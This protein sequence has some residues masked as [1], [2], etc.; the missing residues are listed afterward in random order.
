MTLLSRLAARTGEPPLVIRAS[1]MLRWLPAILGFSTA[2][3]LYV[4]VQSNR[5]WVGDD[6]A[7]YLRAGERF[8]AG[9]PIYEGQVTNQL[10]FLYGPPWAVAV[11]LI[12]L[13]PGAI[14]QWLIL[15][16]DLACLRYLAGSWRVSGY[17]FLYPG[18]GYAMSSGNIDYL[19][20]A[21]LVL[22][23]R[24]SAIPLAILAPAK[25][26][27]GLG[28]P[29]HRWR[30]ALGVG[31]LMVFITLPFLELWPEWI[32]FLLSQRTDAGQMLPIPWFIRLPFALL[33]LLPRKP[34]LTAL[35][36]IVATP[37]FYWTTVV[38]F[39][40]PFRLWRDGDR[41]P[42]WAPEPLARVQRLVNT[43]ARQL[44]GV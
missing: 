26:A 22:A 28:I 9:Q 1:V 34:W 14:L 35:A 10:V 4:I 44:L 15:I 38:L 6:L 29:I 36:V 8:R 16:V 19:I 21:A 3:V 11:S 32:G 43:R 37:G 20:A 13:I 23:W 42:E 2:I 31:A 27:P 25:V 12:S 5:G 17:L 18:T 7:A 24:R 40:A 41:A 33:M 39:L 30:E